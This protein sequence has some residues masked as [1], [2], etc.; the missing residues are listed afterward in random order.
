MGFRSRARSSSR[1]SR[2]A[3][4]LVAT[5]MLLATGTACVSEPAQSM[6]PT[7]VL[8]EPGSPILYEF[9]TDT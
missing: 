7:N 9:Y 3:A 4:L 8:P 5:T 1:L 2:M 6:V